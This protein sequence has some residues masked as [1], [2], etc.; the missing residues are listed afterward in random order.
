M[1]R[2]SHCDYADL[3]DGDRDSASGKTGDGRSYTGLVW[4]GGNRAGVRSGQRYAGVSEVRLGGLSDDHLPVS[5]PKARES[6]ETHP[7]YAPSPV[8]TAFGQQQA[9]DELAVTTGFD[10]VVLGVGARAAGAVQ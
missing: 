1:G 10:V 2:K 6:S 8:I 9:R 3:H 5:S 4:T 7:L